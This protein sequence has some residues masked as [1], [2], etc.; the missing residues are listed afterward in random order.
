MNR[1]IET[2]SKDE[3]LVLLD[4]EYGYRR[5]FWFPKL[6]SEE[7][8]EWWKRLESVDPYFMTP[9]HLP[10]DVIQ[11][12]DEGLELF[13]E[14]DLEETHFSAHIHCDDDSALQ[15]PNGNRVYHHGFEKQ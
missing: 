2:R 10:G 8:I 11:V 13:Q 4:E 12:E 3:V 15:T 6:S 7:L 14:L 5:W 1:D 9:E